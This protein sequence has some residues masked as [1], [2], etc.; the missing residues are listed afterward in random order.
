MKVLFAFGFATLYGLFLR[1]FFGFFAGF[2]EVMGLVFLG[3]VPFVIGFLTITF[4][5]RDKP[6]STGAA[7][8]YPWA[9]SLVILVITMLLSIEGAICWMMIFPFFGVA[10]GIGGIIANR[11]RTPVD[12]TDEDTDILDQNLWQDKNRLSVSLLML[13]PMLL[14]AIEGDRST[15]AAYY[16]L[17]KEVIIAAAPAQVWAAMGSID[18]VASGEKHTY[19]TNAM[20]FPSHL[21]TTTDRFELG[22]TRLAVYENGL[23]FTEKITKIVPEKLLV[24]QIDVDP[25]KIPPTVLDEHIVIGGK[26]LDVLEDTY[27]LTA[28]PD[29]KSRLTLSSHFYINTPFNWYASIWADWVM[30]DLLKGEL[31]LIKK[32]A[33]GRIN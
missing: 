19:F 2:M 32:R 24:L 4:M 6:I 23:F 17:Q 7:F 15:S 28:L 25:N 21:H 27:T 3:L 18:T 13:A 30:S 14:G 10:A 16:T 8:L 20:G 29:G 33:E 26:H 12:N 5:P 31:G 1:L 9:T 11:M 22:G